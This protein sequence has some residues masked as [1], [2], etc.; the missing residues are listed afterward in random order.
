M[1]PTRSPPS[2]TS[3][4]F[5]PTA[6]PAS[7]S[8]TAS[9]P[10]ELGASARQQPHRAVTIP[11]SVTTIEL[12]PSPTKTSQRQPSPNSASQNH[13]KKRLPAE[14]PHEACTIPPVS[15]PSARCYCQNELTSRRN[16]RPASPAIGSLPLRQTNS[17]AFVIPARRDTIGAFAFQATCILASVAHPRQR[18]TSIG[19]LN[20]FPDTSAYLWVYWRVLH[21]I[22]CFGNPHF[23]L[24]PAVSDRGL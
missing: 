1:T 16:R 8:P 7:P 11:D 6:L 19:Q 22:L 18:R 15:P 5:A 13:R 2:A 10:I 20:I 23:F 17:P 14:R 3:A 24:D 4:F 9:P 12:E 21:P